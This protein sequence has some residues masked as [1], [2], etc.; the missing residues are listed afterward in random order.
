[1]APAVPESRAIGGLRTLV[2]APGR[3]VIVICDQAAIRSPLI[4]AGPTDSDQPGAY[5]ELFSGILASKELDILFHTTGR[6]RDHRVTAAAIERWRQQLPAA[7]Q[8]RFRVVETALLDALLGDADLLVSFASPAL[9]AGCRRGLKPVQIGRALIGSEGFTHIFGDGA[10]FVDWLARGE[11]RARLSLDEYSE[12]ARFADAVRS[13]AEAGLA[14]DPIVREFRRL[15]R[16][17]IS[18]L[19]A[20]ADILANPVGALRL[21]FG[22]L[23]GL[24]ARRRTSRKLGR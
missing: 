16:P 2:D 24:A 8:A 14:R 5:I 11:V 1:M 20:I 6:D 23:C 21:L 7:W 12:F 19:Q 13:R 22:T 10:A 17:R 9:V 18:P 4:D 3:G 15:D